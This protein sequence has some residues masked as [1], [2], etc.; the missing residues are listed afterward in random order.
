MLKAAFDSVASAFGAGVSCFTGVMERNL[1]NRRLGTMLWH[2]TACVID[3]D[4]DVD[5]DID[6]DIRHRHD[7]EIDIDTDVHIRQ[8]HRRRRRHVDVDT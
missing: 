6:I 7:T 2:K 3:I 1:R 8:R 5:F 4:K